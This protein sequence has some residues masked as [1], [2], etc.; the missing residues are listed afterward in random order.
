MKMGPD[1]YLYLSRNIHLIARVP[2]GGGQ[3]ENWLPFTPGDRVYDI[4]FDE[5]GFIWVVG[6][7]DVIFR[8]NPADREIVQ[9]PFDANSRS[10]RYYGGYLYV[11]AITVD[12][13]LQR[14]DIWRFAVDGSGALGEPELY[15]EFS[16]VYNFEKG[17][18]YSITFSDAGELFI[19]TDG[20]AGIILVSQ[21]REWE[22][23]YTGL[24]APLGLYFSW[25]E[26]P[27]MYYTRG[28][29]GDNNQKLYRINTQRQ[30]APYYGIQ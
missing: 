29:V 5:Y 2:P 22:S 17:T 12:D 8:V 15:F 26:G 27:N 4:E 30:S 24:I 14:S 18:A 3:E 16:R 1:G 21:S 7:N 10:V 6:N 13:G 20:P 23:F 25:G 19:G 9:F 11:S 28:E